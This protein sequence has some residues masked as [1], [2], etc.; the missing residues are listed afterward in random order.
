MTHLTLSLSLILTLTQNLTQKLTQNL[1]QILTQILTQTLTQTLNLTLTLIPTMSQ[2]LL[3]ITINALSKVLLCLTYYTHNYFSALLIIHIM[4]SQ[5]VKH[6]SVI[7]KSIFKF[8]NEIQL[9]IIIFE[10]KHTIL[11]K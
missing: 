3:W 8:R 9:T 11:K 7:M 2:I 5:Y 6:I 4:I 10:K 1:T